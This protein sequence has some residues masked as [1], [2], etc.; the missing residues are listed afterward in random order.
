MFRVDCL[1]LKFAISTDSVTDAISV[2]RLLERAKSYG[3]AFIPIAM[4]EAGK[5]TRILGLAHGAFMTYAALDEGDETAPGQ[6]TAEDLLDIYRVK[7]FGTETEVYGVIAGDTRYSMSPYIHNAAFKAA[8]M[9]RLFVPL[10]TADLEAFLRRMVRAETSEIDLNFRGFAVTNPYKEAIMELL[11]EIDESART[12]GAVNTIKI[13]NDRL[14]GFNTDADGFML[15]L[16]ER[17]KELRSARVAVIGAGGAARACVFALMRDGA[18]VKI[19]A[20]DI[21][22]ARSLAD[23]FGTAYAPLTDHDLQFDTDILVNATPL[24]TQ[25]ELENETVVPVEL[26]TGVKLVYD[27][28][29]NPRD[30]RLLREALSLIHI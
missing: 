13:E 9:D 3:R 10:Q 8:T 4:G 5:W 22:K 7:E 25:G 16:V 30:T 12:I 24:G 28:T 11:D 19:Y 23:E 26:L 18:E 27:L 17:L 14:I 20:R 6:L 29:Y 21:T 2:W 15:P 1:A